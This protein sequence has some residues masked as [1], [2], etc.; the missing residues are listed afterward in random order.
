MISAVVYINLEQR[1]DRKKNIEDQI[2][3]F[4]KGTT[5]IRIEAVKSDDFTGCTKSHILALHKGIRISEV[6]KKDYFIVL[7]DD[8]V[9]S[10]HV[11]AESF[12]KL[13][14]FVLKKK[15]QIVMLSATLRE[16]KRIKESSEF[17]E[18]I[19]ALSTA[20]YLVHKKYARTLIQSAQKSL[21]KKV[22][23]IDMGFVYLQR[24]RNPVWYCAY[25]LFGR[26]MP[27]YSDIEKKETNYGYLEK[28]TKI[29]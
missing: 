14:E 19:E 7:E 3:K 27:G 18:V 9:L 13:E 24:N 15:A 1:K 25:P 12:K 8:F 17:V 26:Q 20:G 23:P 11:T 2:V 28:L 5:F 16:G 29:Y 22:E 21:T 10:D 6:C 4:P